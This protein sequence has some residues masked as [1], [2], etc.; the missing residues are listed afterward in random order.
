MKV[1]EYNGWLV[2]NDSYPQKVK[3]RYE[4]YINNEVYGLNRLLK[5]ICSNEDGW[6]NLQEEYRLP[7][8]GERRKAF[9]FYIEIG[10]RKILVEFNGQQHYHDVGQIIKDS[11]YA[12]IAIKNG[13][14]LVR[15]PYYIQLDTKLINFF[16]DTKLKNVIIN[17]TFPQGFIVNGKNNELKYKSTLPVE[18]PKYGYELYKDDLNRLML[19]GFEDIVSEISESQNCRIR[20]YGWDKFLNC[21]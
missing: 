19:A 9:D 20:D 13:Y 17:H 14:E 21:R 11:N 2:G 6:R 10:N 5:F 3:S 8:K 4:K 15:I 16:F 1:L 18:F 7:I 12:D